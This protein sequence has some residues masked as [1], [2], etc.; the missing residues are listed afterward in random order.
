MTQFAYRAVDRAGA[1]RRGRLDAISADA[2]AAAL[3]T[4]GFTP[5]RI[6]RA[7]GW[8]GVAL[9]RPRIG[10]ALPR[11]EWLSLLQGIAALLRAGLTIDRALEIERTIV[12]RDSSRQV[13]D[14]LLNALKE[15]DTF[16]D[17]L[18]RE[19][20][21]PAFLPSM[22]RAGELGGALPEVLTRT[23]EFFV[24]AE[25][26]RERVRS[27]MIYPAIL[28]GMVGLTLV[29]IVV[30]VLP[31]FE[32]LFAEAGAV[33]PVPTR[34]VMALGEFTQ[35]Y[36]VV[37]VLIAGLMAVGVE[38]AWRRDA[39]RRR[40]HARVLTV[41]VAGRL[42]TYIQASRFFRTVATMLGNGTTLPT[43][44]RVGAGAMTN[45]RLLEATDRVL[46]NL[47][48][49]ESLADLLARA[50]VFPPVA[51]QLTRVGQETGRLAEMLAEVAE[52]LD[53][54]AQQL[55]ER[56]ITILVP[57]TTVVMGVLVAALIASVLVGV[58]SIN[59]LAF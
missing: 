23:A 43:A 25:Q 58:L 15:G 59:D 52:L 36:G 50:D 19:R 7:H 17:A 10:A 29:L 8:S 54:E 28:L 3:E 27:A 20:G 51:V 9:V 35:Q 33:L 18:G 55:L 31:R 24:R 4:R 11:R 32:R 42:I 22:V 34:I 38:R 16:A 26:L 45:T 12:D 14:R 37:C 1:V 46:R 5:L 2:A 53:R 21:V 13:L 44:I 41:P 6:D 47:R 30:V 57:A 56:L 49:G 48:E 39:V 40:V